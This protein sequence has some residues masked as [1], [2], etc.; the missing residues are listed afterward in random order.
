MFKNLKQRS[1][2][3]NDLTFSFL[4]KACISS[5]DGRVVEQVHSQIQKM[6]FLNNSF[7]G[8]GLVSV[9]AKGLYDLRS[10][11]KVFDEIPDRT[12]VS[13][14][15]SLIKGYA[16]SGKSEEVLNLFQVMI[17]QNIHPENDTM[18]SVL[19]ACSNLEIPSIQKWVAILLELVDNA[20]PEE[21]FS[22]SI[23][24][25]LIYLHGKWG[26]IETSRERFDQISSIG[27]RSVLPWNAMMN[28]YVQNG[29][30]LEGLTLFR[31][32]VED[33]ITEPNHVTM[34]SVLSA[35]AQI[36]DLDL[37]VWVHE[38][39]MSKG[40][41]G[42]IGTNRILATA[43]LDMY[44]KCG[45]LD[46]AKEVFEHA[47]SKDVVLFNAMIMGLAVNSEGENALRLFHKMPEFGIKPNAGTFLG[48]L[49]ACSHSGLLE[50]GRQ[51]FRD[52]KMTFKISPNSEHYASY[53][54]LLARG[55][56]LEEALEVVTSMPFKPNNFVW[57]ALLGG[58][59]LHSRAE[60]AQK[61]SMKLVEADPSNSAGYVMLANAFASNHHWGDVSALRMEMREKEIKKQPGYSWISLDGVVHEFLV[62]C[63]SHPQIESIYNT[64]AILVKHLKVPNLSV[65]RNALISDY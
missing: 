24:T 28:A 8:N 47:E 22:D 48:V 18:V 23:N 37:G 65:S 41:K 27:K 62:G 36:G 39:M 57:D 43:L 52:M 26:M 54:D 30:P 11:L 16:Q 29:L 51:I 32:M 34:V 35:C 20:D 21:I 15:T 17:Q 49:C 55:N 9:Y 2:S 60:L 46:R 5:K 12:V 19:S 13:C 42:I 44:S 64:L 58:C 25:I 61:V 53:I 63:L 59:L 40:R 4:L 1:L 38:Y 56:M 7:V 31:M 33:Q 6:G 50:R 14:W 3:P 45:S 10:A